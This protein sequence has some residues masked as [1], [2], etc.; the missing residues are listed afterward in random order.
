MLVVQ[1]ITQLLG[2]EDEVVIALVFN[3]L[4]NKVAHRT[5]PHHQHAQSLFSYGV[6][7]VGDEAGCS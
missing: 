4:E 2:L 5:A 1:R 3:I 6:L 7:Y